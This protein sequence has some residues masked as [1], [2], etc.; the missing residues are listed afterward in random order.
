MT[1]SIVYRLLRRCAACFFICPPPCN[2]RSNDADLLLVNLLFVNFRHWAQLKFRPFNFQ[3]SRVQLANS[4]R[5]DHLQRD[6]HPVFFG[7]GRPDTSIF[8][9]DISAVRCISKI[10]DF[11]M[12]D[13]VTSWT[14]PDDRESMDL[15]INNHLRFFTAWRFSPSPHTYSDTEP[16]EIQHHRHWPSPI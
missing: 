2:K 12:I 7:Y 14:F 16:F 4:V 9:S 11:Y 1:T 6:L 8:G 3:R 5:A 15:Y 13:C 10:M